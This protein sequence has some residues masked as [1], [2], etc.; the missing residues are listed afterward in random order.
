MRSAKDEGGE[1]L[2]KTAQWLSKEQIKGFFSRLAKKRRKLG[3]VSTD[4]EEEIEVDNYESDGDDAEENEK[5]ADMMNLISSELNVAHPIYYD[6]YDLCE[7]H[8]QNKL[9]GFKVPMLKEICSHFE[10]GFKSKDKK[11]D[12]INT[13]SNMLDKCSCYSLRL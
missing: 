9:L 7:L 5:R 6:A 13:I 10:L 2:F 12:L 4:V 11:Q 1:K 3:V 8:K